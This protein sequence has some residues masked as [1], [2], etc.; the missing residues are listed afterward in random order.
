MSYSVLKEVT[1]VKPRSTI[2]N[3]YFARF[4]SVL[5]NIPGTQCVLLSPDFN[6]RKPIIRKKK[7]MVTQKVQAV[8]GGESQHVIVYSPFCLATLTERNDR[9]GLQDG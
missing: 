9:E 4:N 1:T 3:I 2:L 7:D 8:G 6:L 5:S